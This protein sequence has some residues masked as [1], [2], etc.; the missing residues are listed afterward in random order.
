MTDTLSWSVMSLS[1]CVSVWTYGCL[2]WWVMSACLACFYLSFCVSIW[3]SVRL[4][5]RLTIWLS[6]CLYV[7]PSVRP[8]VLRRLKARTLKYFREQQIK[9]N[10]RLRRRRRCFHGCCEGRR[11]CRGRGGRFL[12]WDIINPSTHLAFSRDITLMTDCT[13]AQER[14]R[15]LVR[16]W[17]CESVSASERADITS[18]KI[19]NLLI[20]PWQFNQ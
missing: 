19:L 9:V 14:V 15:G 10:S 2:S 8:S 3:P 20:W 18:L 1:L 11:R 7:Y 17:V 12:T 13:S 6:I 5:V 4:S 16:K